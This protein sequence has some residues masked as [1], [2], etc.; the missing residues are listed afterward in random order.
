MTQERQLV[1]AST[2]VLLGCFPLK[3][4]FY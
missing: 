3:H 4:L 1:E 2:T